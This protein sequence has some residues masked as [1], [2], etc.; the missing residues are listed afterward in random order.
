MS[1]QND[2]EFKLSPSGIGRFY[3]G[4]S[5]DG[6]FDGKHLSK[7]QLGRQRISDFL[8]FERMMMYLIGYVVFFIGYV[9]LSDLIGFHTDLFGAAISFIVATAIMFALTMLY[10][11]NVPAYILTPKK[12]RDNAG[13]DKGFGHFDIDL[14]C[15]VFDKNGTFLLEISPRTEHMLSPERAVY[16]SGEDTDG[17]GVYDDEAIYVETRKIP[18]EYNAFVFCASND[19]AHNFNKIP[20]LKIRLTDSYRDETVIDSSITSGEADGYVFCMVH[21]NGDKWFYRRIDQ[22]MP[23]APH[24]E[25]DIKRLV[26][27]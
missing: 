6:M 19:C 1:A 4:L 11:R 27:A 12:E 24:W 10:I 8:T 16:H 22:Y 23:F 15:M 26:F 25:E 7:V 5:W 14:H 3:A 17:Q 13:R 9:S 20:D 21:R 18:A 2:I